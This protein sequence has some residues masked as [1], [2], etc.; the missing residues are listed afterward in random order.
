MPVE[1]E[2]RFLNI[3]LLLVGRFDRKELVAALGD[4][5]FE[6]RIHASRRA[7]L[8]ISCPSG[9]L[10]GRFGGIPWVGGAT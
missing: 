9:A 3:D 5:L 2:V 8:A 1:A 4:G 10:L 6:E 7:P